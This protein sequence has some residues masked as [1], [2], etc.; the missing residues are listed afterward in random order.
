MN[1][2]NEIQNTIKK[3]ASEGPLGE[4]VISHIATSIGNAVP[5]APEGLI[6]AS[7][8]G[9]CQEGSSRG[10]AQLEVPTI[11]VI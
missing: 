2:S 9:D 3:M 1:Y 7:D 6:T 4:P 8:A 11:S 5:D 10:H